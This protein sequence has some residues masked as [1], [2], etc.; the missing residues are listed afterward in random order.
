MATLFKVIRFKTTYRIF[1]N[2]DI[3]KILNKLQKCH[4]VSREYRQEMEVLNFFFLNFAV[5]EKQTKA[6]ECQSKKFV[7]SQS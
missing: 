6:E 1:N 2:A 4:R 7:C 5:E 3:F